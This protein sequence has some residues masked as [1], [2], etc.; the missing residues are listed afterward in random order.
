MPYRIPLSIE[1][2]KV[3]TLLIYTL[4]CV[5]FLLSAYF[6]IKMSNTAERGYALGENQLRQKDLEFEN[7]FLKQQVLD[8]QSLKEVKGSNVVK[9][10]IAPESTIFVPPN[11]PLSKRK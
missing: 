5:L 6:F 8:L 3:L 4:V 2:R 9:K 1:V 10:M 11:G 7:R